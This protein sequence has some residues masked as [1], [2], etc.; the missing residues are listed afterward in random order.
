[1][2]VNSSMPDAAQATLWFPICCPI[3]PPPKCFQ[4]FFP[5]GALLE[6]FFMPCSTCMLFYTWEFIGKNWATFSV[7][8]TVNLKVIIA[9]FADPCKINTSFVSER[10][11][12]FL[13]LGSDPLVEHNIA[14]SFAFWEEMWLDK[15]HI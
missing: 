13:S 4:I 6:L 3:P 12:S 2:H 7:Q 1:M 10:A 5:V 14:I 9:F 15:Q 8:A 11:C